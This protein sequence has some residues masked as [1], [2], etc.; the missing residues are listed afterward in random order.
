VLEA[1]RAK[2]YNLRE[3]DAQTIGISLDETATREDVEA[4]WGAFGCKPRFEDLE[5]VPDALPEALRRTS[6]Y[7]THPVFHRHRSE[8][9]MLRYLRSLA[10]KDIALDRS[11]IPLGS[12]T[13]KLNAASEMLPITW[14][15]FASIHPFAPAGRRRAATAR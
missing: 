3:V 7:L 5:D 6:P 2:G 11:M 10:D 8:T 14:D 15:G 9:Q 4:I 12:C 1:A 13:M